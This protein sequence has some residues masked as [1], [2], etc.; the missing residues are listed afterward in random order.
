MMTDLEFGGEVDRPMNIVDLCNGR[1]KGQA[2]A[3]FDRGGEICRITCR[4]ADLVR[5]CEWL[6][7]GKGFTFA[8]LVVEESAKQ[9]WVLTYVFYKDGSSPWIELEVRLDENETSAPS[10][11]GLAHGP[12][13]DWHEREAEDLFGLRFSGHPRLGEFVLHED[14]PEGVNPM[15]RSFD[16]HRGVKR[17]ELDPSW[18]PPTIVVAPGSFAMPVGP[19]FSDFAEASHFLLE[20][21]GEDVIHTIPRFFYKYR[22][23]E[24]IAERQAADR[25]LLLGSQTPSATGRT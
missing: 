7:E 5:L 6:T 11:V 17:R 24:K 20:T 14:W 1:W 18:Q 3:T 22:G 4:A 2:V 23:M 15:R 19:I 13:V 9:A 10:L 16:A 21:V 8:T 25:A 12:S